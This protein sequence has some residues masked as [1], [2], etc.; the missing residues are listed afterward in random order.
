MTTAIVQRSIDYFG[1][2]GIESGVVRI[3]PPQPDQNDWRCE[4]QITWPGYDRRKYAMGIDAWQA[5]QLAMYIV[6]SVI[7]STDAFK[8]GRIGLWGERASTYEQICE[9]FGVKPVEGPPQP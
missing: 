9:L 6:P 3:F 7:F 5:L 2:G 8:D 4:Y 1:D